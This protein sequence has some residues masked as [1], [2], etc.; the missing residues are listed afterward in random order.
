M[1]TSA[2]FGRWWERPQQQAYLKLLE[3][4]RS[5]L[6]WLDVSVGFCATIVISV[7]LI[8]FRYQ[9]IPEY[10]IGQIADQ[11]VRAVQDVTYEDS[12]ATSLRRA[13]AAAG[14]PALYQLDSDLIAEREKDIAAA[15]SG[16]RDILSKNSVTPRMTLTPALERGLLKEL[17]A[18]VGQTLPSEVLAEDFGCGIAGWNH[19]RS[20]SIP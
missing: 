18:R 3:N 17:E 8:G 19:Q 5:K 6:T 20:R 4:L 14:V 1:A 15:F 2:R 13:E 16:A 9:V 10:K 7:I 12:A 11:D